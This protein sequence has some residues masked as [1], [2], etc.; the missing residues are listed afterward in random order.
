[1]PMIFEGTTTLQNYN[2]QA[3]GNAAKF[4]VNI[5][6]ETEP[7]TDHSAVSSSRSGRRNEGTQQKYRRC[8]VQ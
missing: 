6:M 2:H 8:T 5:I 7:F 3:S 4:S 1:M